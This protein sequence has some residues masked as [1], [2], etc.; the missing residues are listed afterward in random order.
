M[1]R[2][3]GGFTLVE[4]LIGI[5]CASIITAGTLVLMLVTMR[6]TYGY[7][8]RM[9]D[10]QQRRIFT[11][12]I[13]NIAANG[14][15]LLR[16]DSEDP[17]NELKENEWEL[18]DKDDT[19]ILSFRQTGDDRYALYGK[20][21]GVIFEDLDAAAVTV[22]LPSENGPGR[23]KGLFSYTV[24]IEKGSDYQ[25]DVTY[26]GS[27]YCRG[28]KKL[29][30]EEQLDLLLEGIVP[31][32]APSPDDPPPAEEET[33][34]LM[35]F[36]SVPA[37]TAFLLGL[38]SQYGNTGQIVLTPEQQTMFDTFAIELDDYFADY[39]E[40]TSYVRWYSDGAW[41]EDTPWCAIFVSWAIAKLWMENP[42][43]MNYTA[44][45][46]PRFSSVNVGWSKFT[47]VTELDF[48]D[49]PDGIPD[50]SYGVSLAGP[51]ESYLP[52][53]GDLVFINN[54]DSDP[55]PD[56]I[57]VVLYVDEEFGYVY[58]IEGNSSNRVAV[59]KYPAGSSMIYGYGVLKWAN[60]VSI[61]NPDAP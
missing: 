37:R 44:E 51:F 61:P 9:G 12:V 53:P 35:G 52:Q 58:T 59:R 14:A 18:L 13:N 43:A 6:T 22:D 25:K 11:E 4:M 50:D 40:G 17:E 48:T 8:M 49:D 41:S 57:A 1:K 19:A 34:D 7:R 5:L 29:G 32:A 3:N 36:T 60:A 42:D 56:H 47:P 10:Q 24:T 33:S 54:D 46:L 20:G 31:P 45:T 23:T 30:E 55:T 28:A 16:P 2:A 39:Y 21:G 15:R 27:V 26:S 38:V